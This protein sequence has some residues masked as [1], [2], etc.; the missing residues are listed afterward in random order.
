MSLAV[1]SKDE[2]AAA[3]REYFCSSQLTSYREPLMFVRGEKQYLFDENG[4]RY[5]DAYN[6][7]A[8]VGHCHP[9]VVEAA[10]TQLATLNTNTR[11][12]H[13]A[14]ITYAKELL[15]TFP[16]PLSVCFFVNSGSE[17][18]DLAARLIRRHTGR[19]QMITLDNAYH[20]TTG[21]CVELSPTKWGPGG[22]PPP[23]HVK[24]VIVPDTYRGLYRRGDP[25]AGVKYAGYVLK[26]IEE[27][28]SE[29][30][31]IGGFF[32]ESIQGCGG[33]IVL[34]DGYLRE[35]YK[36]VRA[37]GGLCVADEVQ[38]GFGR[39]GSHFWAFETQGVV[40]DIVTL[41]KPMGNGYPLGAVI[42]TKEIADSF[43]KIEYFNT[44][45]GSTTSCVVGLTVLKVIKEENLQKNALVVGQYLKDELLKLKES[46]SL[47]GDVRGLGLYV[48]VEFVRDHATLTPAPDV[49]KAAVE[50]LKA[51]K[52][53]TGVDGPHN[54]VL[55]IKP[56][57]CF[58]KDDATSLV[59]NLRLILANLNR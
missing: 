53:L 12:L 23:S 45:G 29:G 46:E 27:F 7:V 17:A 50:G 19:Q 25:E 21:S 49:A 4:E 15:S 2:I 22:I 41:G 34:P 32:C 38:V 8:H 13:P 48:G 33:Q 57:L 54:N 9:R 28:H 6:N 36:H 30:A 11:Y 44:F 14:L 24:K 39:C 3:R 59:H 47:I 31:E 52:I 51:A 18:N 5:L 16:S 20:G 40:P 56:P 1:L 10:S 42:T 43:S 55:R 58:S 35:A 37:H 26:A